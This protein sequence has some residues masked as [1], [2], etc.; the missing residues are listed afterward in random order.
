MVASVWPIAC[1]N[2]YISIV[3]YTDII[4]FGRAYSLTLLVNS[5]TAHIQRN[6]P[7]YIIR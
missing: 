5:K 2:E 3:Y 4:N 1:M 6:T 7:L